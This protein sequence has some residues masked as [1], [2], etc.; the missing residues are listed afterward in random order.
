MQLPTKSLMNVNSCR[1]WDHREHV[2]QVTGRDFTISP[3]QSDML[4]LAH[5]QTDPG[6]CMCNLTQEGLR[7]E[8]REARH[9]D[10]IISGDLDEVPKPEA[11]AALRR[12]EWARQPERNNCVALEASM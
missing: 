3:Y 1:E 7:Q 8:G 4:L 9:G 5:A 6:A 2:F 12:C 11:V 10:I